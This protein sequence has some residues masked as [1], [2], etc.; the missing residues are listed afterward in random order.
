MLNFL[1][2]LDVFSKVKI[3]TTYLYLLSKSAHFQTMEEIKSE[4]RVWEYHR[5]IKT[6]KIV[7][8]FT[9]NLVRI[10]RKRLYPIMLN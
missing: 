7:C 1:R 9:N 8:Q 3:T 6:S 5:D 2:L 4:V 10:K